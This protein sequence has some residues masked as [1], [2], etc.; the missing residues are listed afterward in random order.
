M[1][2]ETEMTRD[3][4]TSSGDAVQIGLSDASSCERRWRAMVRLASRMCRAIVLI[5]AMTSSSELQGQSATP[6]A[7]PTTP[8][9]GTAVRRGG[10]DAIRS[11][12][13]IRSRFEVSHFLVSGRWAFVVCNEVVE[14]D[15]ELQE[16]DLTVNALLRRDEARSSRWQVVELWTLPEDDERPYR[17]FAERVRSRVRTDGVPTAILPDDLPR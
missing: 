17:T 9:A 6:S 1:E 3:V 13:G 7:T 14:A 15:G 10:L 5:A 16:T 12:L 11:S 4:D 2:T 8:A